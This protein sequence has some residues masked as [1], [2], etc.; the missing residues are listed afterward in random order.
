MNPA[1]ASLHPGYMCDSAALI[2]HDEARRDLVRVGIAVYGVAPGPGVGADLGLRPAMSFRTQVTF[3]KPVEAGTQ[4][5]YGLRHTFDRPT[6][7]ATIPVG[8]ADGVPRRLSSTGGEVL[9]AGRRRP[10]VGV[11]T[12]DQLMVDCGPADPVA[13]GD[14]VVLIGEQDGPDGPQRILAEEWADRLGT[15]GYEIVCGIGTRVPR[16]S[17][18]N[19]GS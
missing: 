17:G 5:S 6:L 3:V 14:E 4:V 8:Y 16:R 1:S 11:V 9:L 2:E 15:I 13:V 19:I 7:V 18:R 10:I 12:M